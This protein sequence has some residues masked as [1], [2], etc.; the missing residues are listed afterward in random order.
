MNLEYYGILQLE[1][2]N[3]L[4]QEVYSE[5]QVHVSSA[6]KSCFMVDNLKALSMN[7]ELTGISN[8][9][10]FMLLANQLYSKAIIRKVDL[11]VFYFDMD[12]LK[13][14][15]DNYSHKDGDRAIKATASIL[16]RVFR[17][18]DIVGRVGGDE[19]IAIIEE[20][21]P[22]LEEII[23]KRL[24]D[25]IDTYNQHS[26]LPYEIGISVGSAVLTTND[27]NDSLDEA[28]KRADACMME[29]KRQRKKGRDFS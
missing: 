10:G 26:N 23:K 16:K 6:Y 27:E 29:D 4:P 21:V 12:N 7:D 1:I 25:L 22:G 9:R 19:F 28:I 24:S 5:L 17:N 20:S 18:H 14:I 13:A 2:V 15:N 8:R 11:V 3:D